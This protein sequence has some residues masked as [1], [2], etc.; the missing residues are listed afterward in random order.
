[1]PATHNAV[2]T[3]LGS[4][5]QADKLMIA[6]GPEEAQETFWRHVHDKHSPFGLEPVEFDIQASQ[7]RF[8]ASAKYAF[9]RQGDL[10]WHTYAHYQLPGLVGIKD[11]K[12]VRGAD[13][14][15]W[16]PYTGFRLTRQATLAIGGNVID[17]LTDTYLYVWE[18]LSHK[19]GKKLREMIGAFD[20]IEEQ[21]AWSKRSQH[22]WVPLPFSFCREAALAL[23]VVSLSFH[24][25]FIELDFCSRNDAI[26]NPTG[27]Q[28]FVRPDGMT[29]D[30]IDASLE[31]NPGGSN[32]AAR[33]RQLSLLQDSDLRCAI[34]ANYVYLENDERNKFGK[35]VFTQLVDELQVIPAQ[36][37]YAAPGASEVTPTVKINPRMQ[38]NNVIME[39]ITVVR[40]EG[41]G[42]KH[43]FDFSGPIDEASGLTLDPIR[44]IGIRFNNTPRVNTR[45]AKYFRL[46]Q[47]YQYHTNVP[48]D[49]GDNK[50]FIYVWSYAKAPE[51]GLNP[52][53]GANHTRLENVNVEYHLD[54]RLFTP[55]APNAEVITFGRSKNLLTYKF[56]MIYKKLV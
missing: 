36:A 38:F 1:M 49:H 45:S 31:A 48:K 6:E 11:G 34:E 19:P 39:Y 42:A 21:Q 32:Y 4:K 46:V 10:C 50:E 2:F 5:G 28:I 3:E 14:P 23:P 15:Y 43:Y 51:D 56:G 8:N 47:P 24:Q 54:P 55:D 40:R 16:H 7:P 29:D 25:M 41:Q 44:D 30:E 52:T 20:T 13:A 26:I 18:A 9:A 17:S 35:G 22:L 33:G 53:G 27:A 37:Y 12:V